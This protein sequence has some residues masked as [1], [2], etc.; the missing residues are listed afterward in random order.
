MKNFRFLLFSILISL[1]IFS[2]LPAQ[3]N[4]FTKLQIIAEFP[5]PLKI[6]QTSRS[7]NIKNTQVFGEKSGIAYTSDTLF[8]TDDNGGTWHEII[9]PRSD[10]QKINYLYFLDERIGWTIS[11]ERRGWA[12]LADDKNLSLELATTNDGGNSWT[13]QPINIRPEDLVEADLENVS[14]GFSSNQN[15]IAVQI[16]F[17][18]SSNLR[19]FLFE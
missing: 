11:D 9:L 5:R 15:D 19:G 1:S 13:S 14:I 10:S 8:R 18:T 16:P 2:N 6:M 7:S 4:P 17:Q 3:E 12:I